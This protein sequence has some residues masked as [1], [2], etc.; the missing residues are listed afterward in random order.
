MD[1][2]N[3]SKGITTVLKNENL[4]NIASEFADTLLDAKLAE[5]I[6]KE[7]PGPNVL[8]SIF[9]GYTSIQ[10]T[11]FLNKLSYFFKEI[12]DIP[13]EDREEMINKIDSSASY[14]TKFGEKILYIIDKCDD[15][16]KAEIIGHL[17]SKCM[18][19]EIDYDTLLR[20]IS[21]IDK[22]ILNDLKWFIRSSLNSYD[23]KN[24]SEFL[25][26]GLLEFAPLDLKIDAKRNG[27]TGFEI[28]DKSLK[29]QLSESGNAIRKN[30]NKFLIKKFKELKLR[31]SD[32]NYLQAYVLSIA[33]DHEKEN[34]REKLELNLLDVICEICNNYILTESEAK[35][36]LTD[37]INIQGKFTIGSTSREVELRYDQVILEGDEFNIARWNK[38]SEE[39]I[40]ENNIKK[41]NPYDINS[42]SF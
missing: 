10:D 30:L 8:I 6:L 35:I 16:E 33:K 9:K 19:F 24:G 5:G 38:F 3:I 31:Q 21:I 2:K 41:Y 27:N 26:W 17:T 25:N 40:I 36:V 34:I 39:F 23:M 29:L 7:I 20:C 4:H 18:R 32:L 13:V 22:C 12:K 37:I 11:L 14:R 15:H 1:I 42:S 28:R